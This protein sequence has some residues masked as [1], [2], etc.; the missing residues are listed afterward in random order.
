M[1]RNEWQ[2][3]VDRMNRQLRTQFNAGLNASQLLIQT[4]RLA[5]QAGFEGAIKINKDGL[6]Q[7]SQAKKYEALLKP[8]IQATGK[9]KTKQNIGKFTKYQS[10]KTEVA[11]ETQKAFEKR[12]I[13]FM[14]EHAITDE[15][16][17]LFY[18][19][20]KTSAYQKI[21]VKKELSSNQIMSVITGKDKTDIDKVIDELRKYTDN[22]NTN[23][24]DPEL[25]ELMKKWDKL[26][27]KPK[28]DEK[29]NTGTLT[30]K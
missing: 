19:I 14:K 20:T 8:Y 23:L 17:R 16:A 5:K 30:G 4:K 3:N 12:H 13:E 28:K 11:R 22:T 10:Y 6:P 29:N 9:G 18:D 27:P 21:V 1:A 2:K 25:A 26:N 15:Q 7:F 24:Y